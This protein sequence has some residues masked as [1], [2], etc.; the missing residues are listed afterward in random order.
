MRFKHMNLKERELMYGMLE[1]G[2]SHREIA[3]KLKRTQSTI[4]R[5]IKRNTNYGKRYIPCYAQKRYER[6]SAKQRY[7]A[8][9]KGPEVFVYVREKLRLKWTPAIIS[10]RLKREN[11]GVPVIH[12][13]TIYRY[14]Y[15]KQARKYKLWEYL[16]CGRKKRMKKLGR[17]VR[18]NGKAPNAVS[19]EKRPKYINKRKQVGHWESDNMEGKKTSKTALSVTLERAFRYTLITKMPNQTKLEKTNAVIE[20]LKDSPKEIRRTITMNNGKENYG[21]Q[22]M[23]TQLGVK[24]YFCHAYT[25]YE[26][27]SVERKIKDIRRHIPKG[28]PLNSVSKKK[29]QE[30]EYWLNNKPM[31]CLNYA[32]PHE[33]MQQLLVKLVST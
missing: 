26:K 24:T 21:H 31:K 2:L 33:K 22:E 13:E 32:T 27:G 19:I 1:K 6:V 16:P 15:S 3:K 7:T 25:S 18:N 29:I 11:G 23:A 30:V 4:S 8:P 17:K 12:H 28:V 10:G 9:L 14:I 20:Y 5:E